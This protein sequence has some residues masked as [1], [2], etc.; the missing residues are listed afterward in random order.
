MFLLFS[1]HE[2]VANLE[3]SLK[4]EIEN[5]SKA[6]ISKDLELETLKSSQSQ[7]YSEKKDLRDE[8]D[9]WMLCDV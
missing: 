9:R 5:N 8:L 4:V 2:K 3:S 6:K 1:L 7:L